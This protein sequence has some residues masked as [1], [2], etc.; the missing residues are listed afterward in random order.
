MAHGLWMADKETAAI[1]RC[2]KNYKPLVWPER[3]Y[4]VT[5]NTYGLGSSSMSPF[6]I[7]RMAACVRS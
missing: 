5:T 4:L 1:S 3:F 2:R 6:R 7:A